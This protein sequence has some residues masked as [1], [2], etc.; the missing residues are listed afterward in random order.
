LRLRCKEWSRFLR[1]G[2]LEGYGDHRLHCLFEIGGLL[3]AQK[4][5]NQTAS[6]AASIIISVG[7]KSGFMAAIASLR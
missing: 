5:S 4:A 2:L 3:I 7:C 1:V 6:C